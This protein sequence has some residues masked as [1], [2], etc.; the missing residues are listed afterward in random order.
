M[1][2]KSLVFQI[3]NVNVCVGQKIQL[4]IK[5]HAIGFTII[6]GIFLDPTLSC[7]PFARKGYTKAGLHHIMETVE[8]SL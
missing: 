2:K 4:G 1:G 3:A 5:I 7:S 6:A 8:K